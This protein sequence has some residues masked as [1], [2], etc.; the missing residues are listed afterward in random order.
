MER[1]LFSYKEKNVRI[2]FRRKLEAADI[3]FVIMK[4]SLAGWIE[5]ARRGSR[6]LRVRLTPMHR[7]RQLEP[8]WF[9][10]G[11]TTS[12]LESVMEKEDVKV[13]RGGILAAPYAEEKRGVRGWKRG[14]RRWQRGRALNW[15]WR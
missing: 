4:T 11:Q 12:L 8:S 1:Y 6:V 5:E 15:V 13:E 10:R 3:A 9:R 2:R 14:R 7:L